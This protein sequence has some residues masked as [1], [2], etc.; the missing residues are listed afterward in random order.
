MSSHV[1]S[2]STRT[3]ELRLATGYITTQRV[4]PLWILSSEKLEIFKSRNSSRASRPSEWLI[5]AVPVTK[6]SEAVG[7]RNWPRVTEKVNKSEGN[8]TLGKEECYEYLSTFR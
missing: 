7:L 8:R 1:S 5:P 2:F 4:M 3:T 6:V